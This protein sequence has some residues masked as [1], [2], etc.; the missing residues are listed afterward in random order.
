M[1]IVGFTLFINSLFFSLSTCIRGK[2]KK[3]HYNYIIGLLL[4]C[5]STIVGI[6]ISSKLFTSLPL[7]F[8]EY[9]ITAFS[10]YVFNLYICLNSHMLIKYRADRYY[11]H[12]TIYAFY[13]YWGDIFYY[14]WKD[15]LTTDVIF[16]KKKK[17]KNGK[18]KTKTKKN[19][20][21]K[22]KKSKQ[23]KLDSAFKIKEHQDVESKI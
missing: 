1:I 2:K 8:S 6:A 19:K 17:S 9:F 10:I 3:H 15:L 16:K 22:N 13:H 7:V 20:T 23:L 18:R 21:I 14:F 5:V 4:T 11:E 12:E